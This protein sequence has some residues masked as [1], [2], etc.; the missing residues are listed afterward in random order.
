MAYYQWVSDWQWQTG[1]EWAPVQ[2]HVSLSHLLSE[3]Q[4]G[5]ASASSTLTLSHTLSQVQDRLRVVSRALQLPHSL[6]QSQSAQSATVMGY[7]ARCLSQKTPDYDAT[8]PA[9]PV[10]SF[11]E[12]VVVT[13]NIMETDSGSEERVQI[14]QPDFRVTLNLPRLKRSQLEELIEFYTNETK[15]NGKMR[16]F[17]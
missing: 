9:L 14:A 5:L 13:T 3:E 11:S 4:N 12:E 10:A 7:M 2:A 16:S 8:L 1:Y 6:F 15:A 17:K